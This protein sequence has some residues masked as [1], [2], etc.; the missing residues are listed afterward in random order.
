L[1]EDDYFNVLCLVD[2]KDQFSVKAQQPVFVGDDQVPNFIA[3]DDGIQTPLQ[4]FL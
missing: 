3:D 4:A 1:V 2:G